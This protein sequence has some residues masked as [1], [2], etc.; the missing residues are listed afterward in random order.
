MYILAEMEILLPWLLCKMYL[1]LTHKAYHAIWEKENSSLLPPLHHPLH[2][3]RRLTLKFLL[4]RLKVGLHFL[5]P[6][7]SDVTQTSQ[8]ESVSRS[9]CVWFFATPCTAACQA[10]LSMGFSRQ[11]YWSE[12]LCPSPGDLPDPVIKPVSL[13]SPALAGGLFIISTTWEALQLTTSI[14]NWVKAVPLINYISEH[15]KVAFLIKTRSEI[16]SNTWLNLKR[17]SITHSLPIAIYLLIFHTSPVIFSSLSSFTLPSLYR[18]FW[19]F[20]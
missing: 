19:E 1:Y 16:N 17:N 13:I 12:L 3:S 6:S 11:E 18:A 5:F 14:Y 20:N 8:S 9:S 15:S 10:P 2:P 4:K 7:S